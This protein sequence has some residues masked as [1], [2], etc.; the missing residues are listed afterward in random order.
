LIA[1]FVFT[2]L[3]ILVGIGGVAFVIKFWK[4]PIMMMAQRPMLLMLCL[5]VIGLNVGMLVWIVGQQNPSQAICGS[6]FF[7]IEIALT[8]L[9]SCIGVKEWRAWKVRF[10]SL[11]FRK[12][13]ITDKFVYGLITFFVLISVVLFII[14][15]IMDPTTPDPCYE[16]FC[17][18]GVYFYVFWVY[19]VLLNIGAIALAFVTREVPSVA[20]E[21]SSILH[22]SLF[23]LFSIVILALGFFV[24]SLEV[25]LKLFL[26]SFVFFWMSVCY[27]TLIV[28]RKVAWINMT[29]EEI[30]ALFIGDSK[31]SPTTANNATAYTYSTDER[32]S[33]AAATADAACD[34]GIAAPACAA[35][36]A[37]PDETSK[38]HMEQ[39]QDLESFNLNEKLPRSPSQ[40][41]AATESAQAEAEEKRK[42]GFLIA[43]SDGWEEY[44]DRATGT[45]F[46]IEAK[47]S[48]IVYEPPPSQSQSTTLTDA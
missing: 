44:V 29:R 21:S 11:N 9:I 14:D 13:T 7:L 6:S 18:L 12:V 4:R 16:Y 31:P 10:N 42:N 36:A 48:K 3:A 8:L 26:L 5:G 23:S 22:V 46:W 37:P 1:S 33:A 15:E 2:L 19:L 38:R 43:N 27:M 25:D 34:A 47:T 35:K 30:R 20:G 45:S 24:E 17:S 40:P 32:T 28:F 39:P 41:I